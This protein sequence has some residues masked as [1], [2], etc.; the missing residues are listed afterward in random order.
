MAR[1]RAAGAFE[2]SGRSPWRL[3][4]SDRAIDLRRVRRRDQNDARGRHDARAVGHGPSA[5]PQ[6]AR[7]GLLTA[8]GDMAPTRSPTHSLAP[9]SRAHRLRLH[10]GDE[11]RA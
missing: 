3:S 4:N 6:V 1:G 7:I 8:V 11:T 2:D 5:H 10:A 9:R